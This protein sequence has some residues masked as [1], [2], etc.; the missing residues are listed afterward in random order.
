MRAEQFLNVGEAKLHLK[1]HPFNGRNVKVLDIGTGDLLG[2]NLVSIENQWGL[3][4][5][6]QR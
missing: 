1:D 4:Q 5:G 6:T 3:E 2:Y